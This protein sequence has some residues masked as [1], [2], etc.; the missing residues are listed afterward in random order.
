[1]PIEFACDCVASYKCSRDGCEKCCY[2]GAPPI[3]L[4]RKTARELTTMILRHVNLMAIP[5]EALV[6]IVEALSELERRA[7]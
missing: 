2:C 5:S 7:G 1:M 3:G 6:E 4:S